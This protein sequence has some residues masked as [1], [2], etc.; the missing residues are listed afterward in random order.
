MKRSELDG[1]GINHGYDSHW[2]EGTLKF[3]ISP[4][5]RQAAEDGILNQLIVESSPG[6]YTLCEKAWF[7]VNNELVWKIGPDYRTEH[8]KYTHDGENCNKVVRDLDIWRGQPLKTYIKPVSGLPRMDYVELTGHLE[9]HMR[10]DSHITWHALQSRSSLQRSCISRYR[11]PSNKGIQ[12]SPEY[13]V[14]CRGQSA[15]RPYIHRTCED[16]AEQYINRQR[17]KPCASN[18]RDIKNGCL[19]VPDRNRKPK[20]AS[21]HCYIRCY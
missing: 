6:E 9:D 16:H 10:D 19:A 2:A 21:D 18:N 5:V 8:W 3:G 20:D 15:D 13:E 17:R 7:K 12:H 11:R 1:S 4:Q 14:L